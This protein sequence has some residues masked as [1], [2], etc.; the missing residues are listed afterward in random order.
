M[1]KMEQFYGLLSYKEQEIEW[2]SVCVEL[3]VMEECILDELRY[4]G[5]SFRHCA[6]LYDVYERA[7]QEGEKWVRVYEKDN[8][9]RLPVDWSTEY[10]IEVFF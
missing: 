1:L 9:E 3:E 10:R 4:S 5:V 7:M 6:E 2:F 8:K